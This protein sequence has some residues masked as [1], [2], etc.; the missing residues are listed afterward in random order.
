MHLYFC[1]EET[2]KGSRNCISVH[3]PF[4]DRA[5][6]DAVLRRLSP[7]AMEQLRGELRRVRRDALGDNHRR[8]SHLNRLRQDVED[9][10]YSHD[11]AIH[12]GNWRVA[13]DIE[14][15]L[16]EALAQ[17]EKL[18]RVGDAKTSEISTIDDSVLDELIAMSSDLLALYDSAS[19]SPQERKQVLRMLVQSVIIESCDAEVARARVVWSDGVPD[20]ALEVPLLYYPHRVIREKTMEGAEPKQIADFL[21]GMGFTTSKRT[22]WSVDAI[23]QQLRL[24]RRDGRLAHG[25]TSGVDPGLP[26]PQ[27]TPP[28]RPKSDSVQS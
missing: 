8:R 27:E 9:L 14:K 3:G 11:N 23:V 2:E 17:L 18:E 20:A 4:L 16:E 15:R 22:L 6:R 10:R 12:A 13:A 28:E 24:M 21:N 7:P 26:S 5:I 19:T 25:S 1:L